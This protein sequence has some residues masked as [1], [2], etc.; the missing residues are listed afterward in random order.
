MNNMIRLTAIV[1]A[2]LC[3]LTACTKEPA[4]E[5]SAK[6]EQQSLDAWIRIHKPELEVNRQ[7]VNDNSAFYVEVLDE[8]EA[9]S[10][11]TGP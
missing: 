9:L 7:S 6:F 11:H 3:A 1:A 5:P 4:S 8:G 2:A 10:E